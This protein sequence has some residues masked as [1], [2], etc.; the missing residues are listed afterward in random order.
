MPKL[1]GSPRSISPAPTAPRRRRPSP[2][3]SRQDRRTITV[4]VYPASQL[5]DWTEVYNQ[6]IAGAID[7]AMQPLSTD[8]DKRLAITWFPYTFTDYASAAKALS[9][10]GYITKI[11]DDIIAEQG[12]KLLATY[13]AGMGG[14]VLCQGGRG[15]G[16]SRR[17]AQHQAPRLARRH[18]PPRPDG[19]FRL[20]CRRRSVGRALHRHAD[21]RG[22]RRDRRHAGAGARQLQ[23]HRQDLDSVQRPFRGQLHVHEPEQVPKARRRRTRRS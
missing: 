4:T 19:A 6:V 10:D 7:M 23:G 2:I 17:Q 13:G 1:S 22:R 11:V 21:R 14:A 20:Q 16:Q 18:H 9:A 15:S 5:G 12:L 3:S 8:S